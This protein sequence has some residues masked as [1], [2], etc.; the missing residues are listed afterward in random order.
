MV[1]K[2]L[3]GLVIAF[4]SAIIISFV[5]F[6]F[7]PLLPFNIFEGY[8]GVISFIVVVGLSFIVYIFLPAESTPLNSS[9][10]ETKTIHS[11]IVENSH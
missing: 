1:I 10:Q 11:E 3:R 2:L 5:I 7:S 6:I 8:L 4:A 9:S